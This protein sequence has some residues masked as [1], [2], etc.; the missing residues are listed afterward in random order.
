MGPP[1]HLKKKN[2]EENFKHF[3]PNFGQV[4]IILNNP[5]VPLTSCIAS[6]KTKEPILKYN[7]NGPILPKF[8]NVLPNFG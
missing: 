7:Q 6:E 5:T 2:K 4:R 8:G 3:V 1:K